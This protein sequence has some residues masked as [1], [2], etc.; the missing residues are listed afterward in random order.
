MPLLSI[1]SIETLRSGCV[2]RHDAWGTAG[3]AA[4][5]DTGKLLVGR[6]TG[7]P[8]QRRSAIGAG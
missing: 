5:Q 4:T 3:G 8:S 6:R 1:A 7:S 2:K